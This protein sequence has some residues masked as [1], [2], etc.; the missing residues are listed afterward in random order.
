MENEARD[1]TGDTGDDSLFLHESLFLM[2][3]NKV[4]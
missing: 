3:F 2:L 4:S 1:E